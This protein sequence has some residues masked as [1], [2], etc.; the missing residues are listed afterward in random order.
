[1]FLL[2]DC[3]SIGHLIHWIYLL[4]FIFVRHHASLVDMRTFSSS[5]MN[6][7]GSTWLNFLCIFHGEREFKLWI[8]L[9]TF[10]WQKRVWVNIV[11]K[12]EKRGSSLLLNIKPKKYIFIIAVVLLNCK[13]HGLLL[14]VLNP[15]AEPIRSSGEHVFDL[16]LVS[17]I[18]LQKHNIHNYNVYETLFLSCKMYSLLV[19]CPDSRAQPIWQHHENAFT[20]NLRISSSP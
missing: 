17:H 3:S 10:L 12:K 7:V 11:K 4:L 18:Y 13:I 19:R 20:S 2:T 16:L 6:V 8:V 9:P 5:C 14:R 15:S 1:M